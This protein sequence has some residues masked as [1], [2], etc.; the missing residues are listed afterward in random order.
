MK[1]WISQDIESGEYFMYDQQMNYRSSLGP[2][3]IS[4]ELY[5]RIQESERQYQITQDILESLVYDWKNVNDTGDD[6]D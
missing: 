2:F 3:E 5:E 4:N 1:I 6:C